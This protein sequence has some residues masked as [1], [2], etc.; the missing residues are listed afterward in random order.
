VPLPEKAVLALGQQVLGLVRRAAPEAAA[1]VSLSSTHR[2]HTRFARNELTT[3]GENEELSVGLQVQLGLRTADAH[4]NQTDAASLAALVERTVAIARLA[5][6]RPETMPVLGAVKARRAPLFD[7]ALARLTPEARAEGL[8]AAM[9]PSLEAGLMA[10]GYLEVHAGVLARVTSAG[11]S[12]AQDFTHAEFSVTA[13]TKDGTGSGWASATGR[14][15][16]D[17]DFAAVG[18]TAAE[19][20]V[21]SAKPRALEP[22]RYT[23]ILEPAAT[24]E[25]LEFF[26]WSLDRRAADE[27]RSPFSGKLGQAIASPLV[28]VMS[29][30][31]S[32]DGG[33]MPWDGEG[34]PLAPRTWLDRGVLSNLAV[35]RYWAKAKGLQP[36]GSYGGAALLPGEATREALLAGVR[37]GVL[38]TRIWYTNVVD[39]KTL[40]ITGLTRDGTFLVED[41]QVVAP[42]KNFR[43]NESVLDAL[44]RVD[45]VGREVGRPSR[46]GWSA[47]ALRTHD[48][49]LASQSDAV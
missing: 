41:G 16:S 11:Q 10:A 26:V 44:R 20:A 37:R 21:A 32:A 35:S 19:K 28:T 5:P 12:L 13:R 17:L 43:L 42:V 30:P 25:L 9:A 7:A 14:R 6:E 23:V 40:L 33:M 47:P 29:D 3:A 48:F 24:M 18:R 4:S 15:R 31:T 1:A 2:A 45:A 49:L 27:G 46:P 22:G 36:T 8:A 34:Q 38:I 39:P